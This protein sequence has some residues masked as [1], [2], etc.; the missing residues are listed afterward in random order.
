VRWPVVLLVCLAA[1]EAIVVRSAQ[2]PAPAQPP[3]SGAGIGRA[4]TPGSLSSAVVRRRAVG[5]LRCERRQGAVDLAH[6]ELFADGHVVIVPAGIGL[7][8]PRR[9]SGAYVDGGACRYAVST[10]EPTGLIRLGRRDLRLADL[11]A[12]WGRPLSRTRLARWRA[13]VIAHVGGRLW[14]GD[15]AD[16]PLRPHAQIVLQAGGPV[17]TPHAQYRFPRPR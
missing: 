15:P 3:P 11:F 6:V 5:R 4:Y 1:P 7:A 10:T 13:P 12:V 17:I 14:S 16:I 2:D 8:P 9:R